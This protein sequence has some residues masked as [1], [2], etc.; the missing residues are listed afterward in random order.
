M[1]ATLR[2]YDLLGGSE[3][4]RSVQDIREPFRPDRGSAAIRR[5][6]SSR[7]LD[8][9]E[10]KSGKGA[11]DGVLR[12]QVGDLTLDEGDEVSPHICHLVG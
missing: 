11:G 8:E 9:R 2:Q 7:L 6:S 5:M 12:V 10:K 3:S 4:I 1:P